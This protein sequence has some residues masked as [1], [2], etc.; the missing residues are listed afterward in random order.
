MVKLSRR[1]FLALGGMGA[2][3]LG[4]AGPAAG[5]LRSPRRPHRELRK[6]RDPVPT[7]CTA[8]GGVCSIVA[9]REAGRPV[10]VAP[11][12]A[13]AGFAGVCP[14]AYEALEAVYDPDRMLTPLKRRGPRGSGEWEPVSWE[15]AVDTIARALSEA[16]DRAYVDVGRPDPLAAE[17]LDRLGVSNRI[18]HGESRRWAAVE[19]QR[20]VYGAPLATP[21]LSRARFI[22]LAGAR[23]LDEGPAFARA[24]RALVE[25]RARG[26]RI[27]ALGPYQ[28]ATGSLADEWIPVR[29]GAECLVLLGLMRVVLSQGWYDEA[30][31][32]RAVATP[33]EK[34]LEALV[35][36]S[37]DLVEAASGLSALRLVRLAQELRDRQPAL[38]WVD[39]AGSPQAEALEA[40]AA[41]LNALGGDPEGAG[42]R[43]AHPVRWLPVFEPTLPRVR[44]VKDLLAGGERAS[45]YLAYRTNPVYWSP[46][47]RSV[48]RAFTEPDRI[49]LVV[50]FD[51][52][53]HE[54]AQVADLVLPA[55]AD[56]ELWNLLGGYTPEG[57]PYAVLQQPVTNARGEAAWLRDPAT[58]PGALFDGP[59]RGPRGGARQLG[60][61]L[62][63]VVRSLDP[64]AAEAFPFRDVGEYVRS[65]ADTVPPLAAA[66]GFEWLREKGVWTGRIASYPWAAA[67]GYPTASGLVEVEHRLIHRMP[68][69][70][71]RLSGGD[72]A[73]VVLNHPELDPAFANTRWGREIRHR[74]PVYMNPE[75]AR[76]LGLSAG[77]RVRLKTPVGE[78][79]ARVVL[80]RGI[81]PQAVAVAADFG[82][83]AGGRAAAPEHGAAAPWWAEEGNGFSVEA[84]SP[85]R[86]DARGGQAWKGLRVTVS[87]A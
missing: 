40:A 33:P 45:L 36:Y 9:Y 65:L 66:G 63:D 83:W 51:T 46:R 71:R 16:P 59:P 50:A 57:K 76:R 24:A 25:A 32:R 20:A 64:A 27:V 81:H 78:A 13:A 26:A 79:E 55:A 35:P 18:A 84:L 52:H 85:F 3:G 86:S 22:L 73:L 62:L 23:P 38:C 34:I 1:R 28:G 47:S 30:A 70:L 74:N 39:A 21:D 60:D 75:A 43:L 77:D 53:L 42:V 15:E 48:R 80:V 17:L 49:G 11:N 67:K 2:A 4:L 8:C 68:R 69:S 6:Y 5:V 54:T 31:F 58:E 72:F 29:P 41:V 37:V 19:A 12:P 44:A 7:A 61:L 14:R 82:H 56:L 87:P 10:Q